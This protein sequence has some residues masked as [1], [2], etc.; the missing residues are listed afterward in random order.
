MIRNRN[1]VFTK[2]TST[3]ADVDK[4]FQL[5]RVARASMPT[6]SSSN[7]GGIAYDSTNNKVI[8]SNG[9][10]WGWIADTGA[11]SSPSVSPSASVSP[12]VSSSP[13]KSPSASPSASPS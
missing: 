12:S 11:S 9:S 10:A 2:V 8:F 4:Y 7:E 5:P 13:S 6:A 3:S 1:L